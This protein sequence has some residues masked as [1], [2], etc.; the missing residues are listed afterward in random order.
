M[1]N[2]VILSILACSLLSIITVQKSFA[3]LKGD[4]LLGGVGLDA[5]TQAPAQTFT[6]AVPLY[7]YD[8]SS[9]KN[10]NGDK[11]GVSPNFNMFLTALGG[12]YVSNVKILG[13][14]YGA[15]ILL[16]FAQNRI[17]GNNV[18]SKS[19][20]AF[21]DIYLQPFQL[22]W[23]TKTA[24][25]VFNYGM[26]IPTGKY[27][28]GGDSNA[29]LG[30]FTNEFEAGTTIRLDPK[31]SINFSSLLS[32][33]IHNDKKGTDIK[34]GDIFTAEGGLG[35]TW[36]TFNG[37]KIPTSII[38][39]GIVYYMQFKATNDELPPILPGINP[40]S[41]YLPGKDHVYALG[42]DGNIL[43]TK[44]RMLLGLRWFDEFSAVNRL[45]G[46]TFFVTIAHVFSTAPKKKGE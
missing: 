5:G 13:G 8:A 36:Y 10:A 4:R 21:S 34:P 7:F 14:N 31:G 27:E 41:I 1:K 37:T 15:S 17:Q 44:S 2:K 35:K 24:D 12:T 28:L 45:Q 30:M 46:N 40:N 18:D 32:Y 3:Q 38:K 39:T 43:L 20:F 9:L 33:E 26:Y 23:K 29:G 11:S 19:S 25:F 42:L 16:P 22:G 6:L